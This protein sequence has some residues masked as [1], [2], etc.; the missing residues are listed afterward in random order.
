[1][2]SKTV[3]RTSVACLAGICLR[4][5]SCESFQGRE[6]AGQF[7]FSWGQTIRVL[8]FGYMSDMREVEKHSRHIYQESDSLRA[9][10]S[11]NTQ[12]EARDLDSLILYVARCLGQNIKD[13]AARPDA[14]GLLPVN[15][16]DATFNQLLGLDSKEGDASAQKSI[17]AL[18][19]AIIRFAEK[20]G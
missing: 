4:V 18:H 10:A 19:A 16:P 12:K 14:S 2:S 11:E 20:V 3:S 8:G 1:M 17:A 9:N 13:N 15:F 5:V 7:A 6:A